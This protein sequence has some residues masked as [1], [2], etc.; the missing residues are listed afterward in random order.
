MGV[1]LRQGWGCT[2]LNTRNLEKAAESNDSSSASC[3][4][5]LPGLASLAPTYLCLSCLC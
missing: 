1:Q 5:Q 2:S 3:Q 4:H